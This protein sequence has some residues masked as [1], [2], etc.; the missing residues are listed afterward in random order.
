[1]GRVSFAQRS[2]TS[3]FRKALAFLSR[4]TECFIPNTF[5]RSRLND[6]C[7]IFALMIVENGLMNIHDSGQVLAVETKEL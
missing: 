6:H 4:E 3:C 1:M 5:G 2:S 7:S